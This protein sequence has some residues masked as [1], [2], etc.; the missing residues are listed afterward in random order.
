MARGA[1]GA[2]LSHMLR[3]SFSFICLH[4]AIC[5]LNR[6]I[7]HK[8]PNPPHP[9]SSQVVQAI[10]HNEIEKYLIEAVEGFNPFKEI[11][12]LLRGEND[13]IFSKIKEIGE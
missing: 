9:S 4:P 7:Y 5:F 12:C 8:L 3:L 6:L 11:R 10:F 1:T 13:P 2:A